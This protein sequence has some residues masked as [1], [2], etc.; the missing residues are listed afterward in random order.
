MREQLRALFD[1]QSE[2]VLA[3]SA[4]LGSGVTELLD[5]VVTMVPPPPSLGRAATMR[6]LL[7]DSWYDRYHGTINLIQVNHRFRCLG[8]VC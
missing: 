1:L 2:E 4:K 8:S 5:R 3:V 7:F 6:L